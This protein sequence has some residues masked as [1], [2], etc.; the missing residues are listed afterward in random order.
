MNGSFM[1]FSRAGNHPDGM[2]ASASLPVSSVLRFQGNCDQQRGQDRARG[3]RKKKNTGKA[4]CQ[5]LPVCPTF[6]GALYLSPILMVVRFAPGGI[7]LRGLPSSEF[8]GGAFTKSSSS[9]PIPF[10]VAFRQRHQTFLGEGGLRCGLFQLL[11]AGGR[12]VSPSSHRRTLSSSGS[13]PF[14]SAATS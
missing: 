7:S 6:A 10:L 3:K 8:C 14:S 5:Y 9:G 1:W 11:A 4:F 13:S 2:K 12:S